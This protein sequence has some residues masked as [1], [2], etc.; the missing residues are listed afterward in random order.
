MVP[1]IWGSLGAGAG[2][3]GW[4]GVRG[5]VSVVVK[6]GSVWVSGS[7]APKARSILVLSVASSRRSPQKL[8]QRVF[9]FF[10]AV[11]RLNMESRFSRFI[12]QNFFLEIYFRFFSS[13][14]KFGKINLLNL[15]TIIKLFSGTKSKIQV[16]RSF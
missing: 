5:K 1:G 6:S 4:V 9:H 10:Q 16:E 11:F 15:L 14:K 12:F 7:M 13:Q 8:L 2:F 3:A